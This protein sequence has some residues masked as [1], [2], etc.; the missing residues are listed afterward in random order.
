MVGVFHLPS[1]P[2]QPRTVRSAPDG[3]DT[4]DSNSNEANGAAALHSSSSRRPA[5][6]PRR[7]PASGELPCP[8]CTSR[9]RL[10]PA[11][12][13]RLLLGKLDAL[14]RIFSM[15]TLLIPE[16][17]AVAARFRFASMADRSDAAAMASSSRRCISDVAKAFVSLV[18]A[19]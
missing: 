16:H 4:S 11:W 8:A 14:C 6:L 2:R 19:N 9:C 3:Q 10:E 18:R 5:A 12:Q 7:L 15:Q 13:S 1:T 17:I